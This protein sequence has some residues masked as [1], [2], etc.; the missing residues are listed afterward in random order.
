MK[1]LFLAV[2]LAPALPAQDTTR[3]APDSI[4][5][6]ALQLEAARLDP[7]H[8][9]LDLYAAASDLRLRSIAAERLPTFSLDGRAQYQS[10]VTKLPVAPPGTPTPPHHAYDASLHARQALF[11]ATI[12]ARRRVER[13]QLGESLAQVRTTTFALQHEVNDAFFAIASLQERISTIDAALT[14]LAAR[15]REA[16]QRHAAGAALPGDTAA[17]AATD[18]KSVV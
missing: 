12:G 6:A 18:R 5:L 14:D 13:A 8:R 15:R 9:Q 10:D 11:D 7:R 3:S 16:S 1:A 4:R 2:A 17:L